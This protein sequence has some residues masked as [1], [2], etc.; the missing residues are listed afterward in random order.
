MKLQFLNNRHENTEQEYAMNFWKEEDQPS[1]FSLINAVVTAPS[2]SKAKCGLLNFVVFVEA[3]ETTKDL[4]AQ[5]RSLQSKPLKKFTIWW[6]IW[7]LKWVASIGK[8]GATFA[9]N[10]SQTQSNYNFKWVFFFAQPQTLQD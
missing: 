5:M 2:V 8:M 3:R 10:W 7:D 6:Y 1:R 9:E 4:D